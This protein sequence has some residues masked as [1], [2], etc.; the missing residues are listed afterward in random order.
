MKSQNG[1]TVL[2]NTKDAHPWV[3]P[4]AHRHI[5][6]HK[7]AAGFVLAHFALW[8]HEKIEPLDKGVWDEWGWAVRNVRQS[9]DISN[10]ASGTAVDLNATLHPLGTRGTFKSRKDYALIRARLVWM[11]G[12]IRWG[13][14]YAFRADEMHF[15]LN[16]GWKAV[17]ALANILKNTPRGKRILAA[18]KGVTW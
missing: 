4:G 5:I 18:N 15:E 17:V 16:K 3:I 13:G 11:L 1:W 6:M 12:V 10:H 8:F 2:T 7:G 14:D 9:T